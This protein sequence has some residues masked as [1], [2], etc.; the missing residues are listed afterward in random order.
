MIILWQ[1]RGTGRPKRRK[2]VCPCR[3]SVVA[4]W[5][6]RPVVTAPPDR[7]GVLPNPLNRSPP[8]KAGWQL[9]HCRSIIDRLSGSFDRMSYCC[10]DHKGSLPPRIPC[11]RSREVVEGFVHAQLRHHGVVRDP[12]PPE[13]VY[14]SQRTFQRAVKA[15]TGRRSGQRGNRPVCVAS[16]KDAGWQVRGNCHPGVPGV[17][18]GQEECA[19]PDKR[20]EGTPQGFREGAH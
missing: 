8:V 15:A 1:K 11:R 5:A 4:M 16:R 19:A 17:L 10:L 13:C 14:A 7:L 9:L 12:G 18:G 6:G 3:Y 20:W 2:R